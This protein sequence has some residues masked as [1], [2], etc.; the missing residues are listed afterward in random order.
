MKPEDLPI[1]KNEI[2][3]DEAACEHDTFQD[4]GASANVISYNLFRSWGLKLLPGYTRPMY[5]VTGEKMS[6][7]G[8]TTFLMRSRSGFSFQ[9]I[10]LVVTRDTTD[11]IIIGL[12]DI[13]KQG[14]LP[15][16]WPHQIGTWSTDGVDSARPP[17]REMTRRW[18]TRA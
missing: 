10:E 17:K 9:N 1:I 18:C 3:T 5:S 4:T 15:P 6:V 7:E 14:L 12:K 2:I 8:R 13:K 11:E 16:N